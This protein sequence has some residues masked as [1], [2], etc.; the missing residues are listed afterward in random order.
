MSLH[1][2]PNFKRAIKVLD[3]YTGTLIDRAL[4]E[5]NT[6]KGK[7]KDVESQGGKLIFLDELVKDTNDKKRIRDLL[8]NALFG[9][10]DTT[11]ALL[12]HAFFHLSR[13]PRALKKLR[14]E[15]AQLGGVA[16]TYEQFK[17]LQYLR[18]TI[19]ESK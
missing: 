1:R 14:E 7:L 19:D 4:R 12:S 13:H 17:D 8:I 5:K 3:E 6:S 11:M 9:G 18:W 2:D 15:I 16:P 10:R